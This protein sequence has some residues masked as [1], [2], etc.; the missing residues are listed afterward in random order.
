M[1]NCANG[2]EGEKLH[3]Q[4]GS[5]IDFKKIDKSINRWIFLNILGVATLSLNPALYRI[6]W[7]VLEGKYTYEAE[8]KLKT[9]ICKRIQANKPK[10][11]N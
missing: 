7:P 1:L 8:Y 3:L 11:C 9:E 5:I 10:A 6:P 2:E 4:A